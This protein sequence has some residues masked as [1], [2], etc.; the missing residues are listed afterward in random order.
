MEW[1]RNRWRDLEKFSSLTT[2]IPYANCTGA[3]KGARGPQCTNHGGG[4]EREAEEAQLRAEE[5]AR[6]EE[7]ERE[8]V[9][10]Y[11]VEEARA[12]A[13]EEVQAREEGEWLTV[14]RSL[15]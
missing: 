6:R 5:E 1:V 15:P 7:E 13:E 2:T 14:D 9:R 8:R 12:Q 4:E 10:V 3:Q 11:L